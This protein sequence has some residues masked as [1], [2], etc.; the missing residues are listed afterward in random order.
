VRLHRRGENAVDP[1]T[2]QELAPPGGR[3]VD[4]EIGWFLDNFSP[5]ELRRTLAKGPTRIVRDVWLAA[6]SSIVV[7]GAAV[8][9]AASRITTLQVD[10]GPIAVLAVVTAGFAFAVCVFHLLRLRPARELAGG[11][12]SADVVQA[13]LL[14]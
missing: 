6:A 4:E 11:A 8:L 9:T 10:P 13:H 14:E 12:V 7:C 2:G 5:G 1:L 3:I